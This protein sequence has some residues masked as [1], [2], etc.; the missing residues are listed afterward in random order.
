MPHVQRCTSFSTITESTLSLNIITVTLNMDK[1][2]FLGISIVGQSG[3]CG[4]GG[5]HVGSVMKGGAVALDGRIDPGDMLLQVNEVDF[6]N[7]SN[8]DA[9]RVL[10]EMV[11]KPG[12]ITLTVAKCW[13][14]SPQGYFTL[15]QSEP[16][17]PI[18]TEAWVQ[19]LAAMRV[20]Y[21]AKEMVNQSLGTMTSTSS[22]L[23][24]SLPES[25]RFNDENYCQLHVNSD[26]QV[27]VKALA[28]SDSGL[29]VRDRM[30]LKITIPNAFIGSDLVDWLFSR[31]QG[32]TDRREARKY[33]S[34]LLKAGYIRHTVNKITFSE[35]CYYVFGD[36]CGKMASIS[37][38]ET[39]GSDQDTLAPLPRPV[40]TWG[41]APP[42][43]TGWRPPYPMPQQMPDN[44]P[45]NPA[46]FP[47]PSVTG[48][49]SPRSVSSGSQKSR[50][51]E[52]DRE[53]RSSGGSSASERSGSS[54]GDRASV[55]ERPRPKD[56]VSLPPMR[57]YGRLETM[58]D[59]M[60]ASR[61]SF[62]I[63]LANPCELF[64]D[65]M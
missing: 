37:I 36:L 46:M 42:A 21:Q 50:E 12:P 52:V 25:D 62:Q 38:K 40:M 28:S 17:R 26:M 34:G 2:N 53:S 48:S 65:V 59:N 33:A 15:P 20:E 57:D 13:D 5:I 39:D 7:M 3:S 41:A 35:Q 31:V 23:T 47:V 58:P 56:T 9:V 24:S 60:A 61:S 64:V 63:A 32:F 27:I 16:V 49:G 55:K 8:D 30:W 29:D 10:R 11:H 6:Q 1:A 54:K 45:Y 51:K 14:P 18:N 43:Y 4:D 22:S 19:Q 44:H